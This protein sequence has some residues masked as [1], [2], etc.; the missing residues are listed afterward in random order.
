MLTHLFLLQSESPVIYLY[1][2][3]FYCFSSI[4]YLMQRLSFESGSSITHLKEKKEQEKI[5]GKY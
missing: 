3:G 1:A 2:L 4:G 5:K